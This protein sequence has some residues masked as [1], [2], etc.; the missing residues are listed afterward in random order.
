[1]PKEAIK[2]KA[3]SAVVPLG[4]IAPTILKMLT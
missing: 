1:M 2:L 4:L 3:A